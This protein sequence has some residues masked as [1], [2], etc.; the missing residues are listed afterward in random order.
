MSILI[1]KTT[2]IVCQGITGKAGA[3][4]TA[5]C[6]DYGSKIVAGVVPGKGGQKSEHGI[7]IF[8]TAHQAIAAE[9][10]DVSMVFVPAPFAADAAMEA[11]DAG[12]KLVAIITEGIPTLDMIKLRKYLDD[13]DVKLIGPNCPGLITPGQCKIGIMPGYIHLPAEKADKAVGIISRS[14]TL[15]YEA[16]WQCT[17]RKIG[18]STCVGIGGDPVKGLNFVEL[19]EMFEADSETD[20]VVIIGEIGGSDEERAAEYIKTM[21]KPVVA[22]IAGR[23]APPG[24]RMGHA[25]AIISGS[26]GTAEGK[27]DALKAAGASIA[28]SPTQIGETTEKALATN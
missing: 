19:L 1:D 23:T 3:F 13:K 24:K 4:H 28:D 17:T 14:G 5:Q 25:G 16:V 8:D 21:S 20:A 2:R 11:A 15:T 27:I 10:A 9:G 7:D 18:Q 22:F 12:V 6:L 26:K